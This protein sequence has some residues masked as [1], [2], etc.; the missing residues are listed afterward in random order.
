MR[1]R[2]KIRHFA[3]LFMLVSLPT[4]IIAAGPG[5]HGGA[6]QG[7]P[8]LN[9][10]VAALEA[11]NEALQ[12]QLGLVQAE[13]DRELVVIDSN[14]VQV[15]SQV[16]SLGSTPYVLFDVEGVPLFEVR[17]QKN[18]LTGQSGDDLFFE[19]SNCSGQPFMVINVTF[20]VQHTWVSPIESNQP[21]FVPD[22]SVSSTTRTMFSRLDQ[23]DSCNLGTWSLSNLL[24]ALPVFVWQDEFTPPFRVITRGEFLAMQGE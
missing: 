14:G 13:S 22:Q 6:G 8:R 7:H 23:D 18:N 4:L 2:Y 10:R 3:T 11:E 5:H 1:P 21:I 15:G 12:Q 9:A 17:V 20:L 16:T 19:S 24:P